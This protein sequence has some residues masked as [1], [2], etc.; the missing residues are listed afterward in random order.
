MKGTK[1]MVPLFTVF[2]L[3]IAMAGP[4]LA[5]Q[6]QSCPTKISFTLTVYLVKYTPGESTVIGNTV[7]SSKA[8][9]QWI[10]LD[11]TLVS[12]SKE[13]WSVTNTLTGKG[14]GLNEYTDTYA[15][16]I[17]GTGVI[18]GM[19]LITSTAD[20]SEGVA[21]ILGTGSSDK[22]SQITEISTASWHPTNTP[23]PTLVLTVTGTF[24]VKT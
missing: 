17:I 8:T 21:N 18:K 11:G 13:V 7:W 16:G 19:T 1:I 20:G 14:S 24:T 23:F 4:V 10:A 5:H 6:V 2:L 15:N 9:I 3:S 22:Y 12:D